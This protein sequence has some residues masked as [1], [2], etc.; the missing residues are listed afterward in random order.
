MTKLSPE[1]RYHLRKAQMDSDRKALEAQKVQQDLERLVLELDHKY[2]LLSEGKTIDPR[3]ASVHGVTSGRESNG[4]ETVE[5][6]DTVT[7]ISS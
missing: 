4:K 3:T 1:D 5:T 2:G 7:V 6:L